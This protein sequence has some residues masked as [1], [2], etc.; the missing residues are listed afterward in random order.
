MVSFTGQ[1]AALSAFI[2]FFDYILGVT[3]GIFGGLIFGSV[4]ESHSMSLLE[5]APDPISAGARA[6]LRPFVRDD[7]YLRSLPPG[8]GGVPRISRPRK[9]FGSSGKEV[10]R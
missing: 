2:L 5:P 3:L 9:S 6:L 4:R 8:R 1:A 7:G 10:N